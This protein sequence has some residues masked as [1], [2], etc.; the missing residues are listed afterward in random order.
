MK[1]HTLRWRYRSD[2]APTQSM[3]G[4]LA[5]VAFIIGVIVIYVVT[6]LIVEEYKSSIS[7]MKIFGYRKK[8]INSLL[9]NSSTIVVVI[10]Y[11]MGIPLIL[12]ALGQ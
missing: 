12:A 9:L 2:Y 6:S 11:I 8:E 7:L 1:K 5:T 4:F 3:I 10:G